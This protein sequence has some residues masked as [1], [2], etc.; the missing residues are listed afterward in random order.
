LKRKRIAVEL[1][2]SEWGLKDESSNF[3]IE[4]AGGKT[5][6][7]IKTDTGEINVYKNFL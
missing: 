6:L 2:H 1:E 3:V 7:E 4:K 5:L